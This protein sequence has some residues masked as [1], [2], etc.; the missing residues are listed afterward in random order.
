MKHEGVTID[1]ETNSLICTFCG[2]LWDTDTP[3]WRRCPNWRS[4]CRARSRRWR[5]LFDLAIA[6][7]ITMDAIL[8]MGDE[9]NTAEI[10]TM[11]RWART[12]DRMRD[13]PVAP[14]NPAG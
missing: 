1:S 12:V 8:A 2:A 6:L 4:L 14:A 7:E 10:K 3:G 13:A 5:R 9:A 11:R